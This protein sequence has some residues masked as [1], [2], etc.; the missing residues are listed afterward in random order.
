MK[1][2]IVPSDISGH[3]SATPSK[4]V[5]QRALALATMAHGQSQLHNIGQS[6]DVKAAL[7][8]CSALGAQIEP[9]STGSLTING[10]KLT[11]TAELHCGESGLALRMFT[12]IAAAIGQRCTIHGSGTLTSRPIKP[13]TDALQSLGV[14]TSASSL[15]LTIDGTLNGGN[16]S[17][18]GQHGSQVLSGLLM[19]APYTNKALCIRAL[20][21]KSKPYV[22][23]TV[24][25]MQQFGVKVDISDNGELYSVAANQRYTPQNLTIE[26]DWSG[27]AFMLCAAAIAGK[28]QI[29]A[30]STTS[31]QPDRAVVDALQHVG[32]TV[33]L[34]E[35]SITVERNHLRSFEFDATHCPDLIPPLAAL[36]AN[37]NGTSILHGADRLRAKESDRATALIE[38]F[39][40]MHIHIELDGNTL[41]VHGSKPHAATVHSHADHRIAMACAIAALN[42]NGDVYIENA[43]AVNKSYPEFWADL[44]KLQRK[45]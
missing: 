40:K 38:E 6:A 28:V 37:C 14:C 16:I 44:D 31:L 27:A 43:E 22:A 36:A 23:L 29:D 45:A 24:N 2:C 19:A 4:S 33:Q 25:L 34:S 5:A 32:A 7:D 41:L 9:T 1:K 30:L 35:N 11:G 39:G 21:L 18:D 26:G 12:P 42:A 20:N 3:I 8:I 17:I 13:L 10:C 15:P